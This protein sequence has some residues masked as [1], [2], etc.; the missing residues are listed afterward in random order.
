MIRTPFFS[1]SYPP[2][3]KQANNPT[4]IQAHLKKLF[5]GIHGVEFNEEET[6]ITAMI[7][8][9]GEKASAY[10]SLWME[11]RRGLL[12]NSVANPRSWHCAHLARQVFLLGGLSLRADANGE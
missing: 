12:R 11:E 4:I 2:T 7:S 6:Q 1:L 5:Q 10:R 9:A 8:S 3:P